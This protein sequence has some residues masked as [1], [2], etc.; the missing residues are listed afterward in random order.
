MNPLRISILAILLL[1]SVTWAR[2]NDS[3]TSGYQFT[4]VK[5]LGATPVKN[6]NRTS[7]CWSFSALSLL[8]SELLRMGKGPVD[9]SEMFI[10]RNIYQRKAEKFVRMHGNLAFAP[11]GAFNDVADVIRDIGIVPDQV[12]PG[13]SYGEALH[14]HNELDAVLRAVVDA[15]IKAPNGKLTPAWKRSVAGILDGYLGPEPKEFEWQGKRW[16]PRNYAD[17]ALGIKTEDYILL[18]SFTHHPFYTQFALEVPDNWSYGLVYNIPLDDMLRTMTHAIEHGFTIAW[19]SDVSE[20]GF[21]HKKGMAIVPDKAWEDM[22]KG[23]TD[24]VFIAPVKEKVI[25]QQFRQEGFDN[26]TTQDDHGMH[27]IGLSRDVNGGRY[28][29]VKNSWGEKNNPYGGYF[30]ASEAYVRYKTTSIML[31]KD[32]IPADIRAKLKL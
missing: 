3:T 10:V 2:N 29:Y 19:A 24:S 20:K 31:H 25:T 8:E 7:T 30:H 17:Q 5:E 23:E 11:G 9:L 4:M 12:Y 26:Y 16:T 1:T 27:I 14:V 15:L 18:S 6:Q 13:L 32:A 21:N 22:S 28:F